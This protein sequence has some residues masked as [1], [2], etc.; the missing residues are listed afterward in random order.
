MK[1]TNE[2]FFEPLVGPEKPLYALAVRSGFWTLISKTIRYVFVFLSQLILMN[3]LNPADFGLMRFVTIVLGIANLLSEAGL[4]IAIVQ[5]KSLAAEEIASSFF[6]IVLLS[7]GLYGVIFVSAPAIA[8][9][10]KNAEL[11]DLIRIGGMAAPIGGLSVVQRGL[12]QRRFQYGKLSLIETI[13]AVVGS[14]AGI[15]LGYFGFRVWALVWSVLVYNMLSTVLSISIGGWTKGDLKT[16]KSSVA[17]WLFGLGTVVQRIIDYGSSNFDY[18]IVGKYFGET[19][20]GIYGMA[21]V[22]ITLPQFALGVIMVSVAMSAFSRFQ[23]NNE[24]LCVAF[25]R[26]TRVTTALSIPY[27]VLVFFLAPELMKAIAFIHPSAQW[28][29]AAPFIKVLAPMGLIYC[30]NSYPGIV[31]MA[32]GMTKFRIQWAFFSFVALALAVIIGSH[33]GV[34]GICKA[35]LI[36]ALVL[37]PLSL[38]FNKRT[39]GLSPKRYLRAIMPS[40]LCGLTASLVLWGCTV[41]GIDKTTHNVFF[42][43]AWKNVLCITVYI[44]TLRFVSKDAYC[45]V[46]GVIRALVKKRKTS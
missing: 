41:L 38:F 11:I 2:I 37:F 30:L 9:F 26:L 3:F 42:K 22:V 36:R 6:L 4:G 5:K 19:A 8:L 32:K 23:E 29:P 25:I 15:L 39:F 43:I 1:S 44:G 46:S 20:L 18:I 17:L 7:L 14:F 21:F 24:R 45:D 35:L 40:L 13:S 12:M 33:Y 31:W 10:F 27:F 28:V 16:L 34:L